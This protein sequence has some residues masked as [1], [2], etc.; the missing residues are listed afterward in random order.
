MKVYP[1]I[2]DRVKINYVPFGKASVSSLIELFSVV[3]AKFICLYF[4]SFK[5]FRA[6][7]VAMARQILSVNMVSKTKCENKLVRKFATENFVL[8]LT[9]K[10]YF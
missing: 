4:S 5:R 8:S 1:K 7:L 3:K 9:G 6:S 2:K 10:M